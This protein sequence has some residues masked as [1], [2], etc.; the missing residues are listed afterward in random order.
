MTGVRNGVLAR[1]LTSQASVNLVGVVPAGFTWLIK[2]IHL[3][4][5]TGAA[6]SA[7]VQ[8]NAVDD[9]AVAH[10]LEL[11]LTPN[12]AQTWSGWTVAGPGDLVYLFSPSGVHVWIAGA[13]LPGDIPARS[14]RPSA[15]DS[16]AR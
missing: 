14:R 4:N 16:E 13:E 3:L 11:T 7:I 15:P 6:I 2:T 5:T 10:V 12:V 9:S 1:Q 8:I